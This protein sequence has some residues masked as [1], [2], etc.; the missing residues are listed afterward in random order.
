MVRSSAAVKY[1]I[2][3]YEDNYKKFVPDQNKRDD[4]TM[5]IKWIDLSG[6]LTLVKPLQSR[7][8]H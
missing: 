2:I 3:N 7:F 6:S 4:N 5:K 1:G 8:N